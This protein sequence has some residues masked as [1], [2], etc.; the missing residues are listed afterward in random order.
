MPLSCPAL[1]G[2]R[3]FRLGIGVGLWLL[4]GAPGHAGGPVISTPT[5][6]PCRWDNS[7]PIRYVVDAGPFGPRSHAQGV[8]ML[9]QALETWRAVPSAKL[10]FQEMQENSRDIT[11]GNVMPLL[12]GLQAV[13]PCPIVLDSDGSVLDTLLGQGAADSI[14]G[15]GLPWLSSTPNGEIFVGFAALNGHYGGRFT[16]AFM[17]GSFTHELGH[18]LNLAHSQLNA[19]ALHDGDPE[20]EGQSPV[21]FYRGPNARGILHRDDIA[22]VSS[23]YPSNDFVSTTGSIH[24]RVLLP[25]GVTG[26][27]GV[28]VVARRAGDPRDTAVSATSGH[29]FVGL[30]GGSP[31]PARLGE[32]LIP[33][34]PPGS[35][36]LEVSQLEE[37][38]ATP[39]PVGY[40]VGG[41][42]F[43]HEGSTARDSV[44]TSTPIVVSAGQQVTGIDVVLNGDSLGAPRQATETEPNELPNGQTVVLPAVVRGTVEETAGST[45]GLPVDDEHLAAQL[46]DV[47]RVTLRDWTTLTAILSAADRDADLD[48]YVVAVD[49]QGPYAVDR[50][51][52]RGTPP[53]TVQVRLPAGRFYI[54]VHQAGRRA[55]AYTL[56]LLASPSPEPD[57]AP[58]G[59]LISYFVVGDVTTTGAMARWQTTSDAPSDVW[60]N[61]PMREV[62]STAARR[63]HTL[64]LAGLAVDAATLAVAFAPSPAGDDESHVTVRAATAPVAGEA[65]RIV[66]GSS[67]LSLGPFVTEVQV[68]LTNAGDGDAAKVRIE[69]VVLPTGWRPLSEA[70]AFEPLPKGFDIGGIGAHGQAGFAL[71]IVRVSGSA[72]P[73]ITVKGSYTDANGAVLTF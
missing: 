51:I 24:G 19:D 34:L 72:A 31:D 53:E 73:K 63:D 11:G 29:T 28:Q 60:Y 1:R 41:P 10:R 35:Y 20:N 56:Q 48:L 64:A 2:R 3:G 68:R 9:R 15:I 32:F 21:M 70:L 54:G 47:Y 50:S 57:E 65:P 33:G 38:P 25:D 66:V 36:T 49:S 45:A 52:L 14:L 7:R 12:N 43:W 26:L 22:W 23:F 42:K 59:A 13:D 58:R 30:G 8:A 16:D 37:F 27:R 39:V 4:G 69:Q 61:R 5:G 17:L 18:V 6:L 62:G 71:R 55:T 44:G 67:T 40:L 46:Q